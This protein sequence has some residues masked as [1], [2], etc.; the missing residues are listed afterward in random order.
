VGYTDFIALDV[1]TANADFGSFCSIGLVQF[2]SGQ[3]FKSLTILVDPEDE[4]D[5]INIAIH[6]IRP[7]HVVGKP[8]M[9]K[10]FPVIGA[11]LKDTVARGSSGHPFA[12]SRSRFFRLSGANTY[13]FN[14]LVTNAHGEAQSVRDPRRVRAS[15]N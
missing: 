10:V 15:A 14:P 3:V 8:T 13:A 11:A 9:A 2:R 4:F 12:T 7:E 6:G 5:P 1:A